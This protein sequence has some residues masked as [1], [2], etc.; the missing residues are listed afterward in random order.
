MAQ[1]QIQ[2]VNEHSQYILQ[3]SF[4]LIDEYGNF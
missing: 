1:I 3:K 2:M 4:N